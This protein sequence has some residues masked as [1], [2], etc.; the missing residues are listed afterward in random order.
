MEQQKSIE[1][2]NRRWRNRPKAFVTK[3]VIKPFND[4]D[5]IKLFKR[6]RNIFVQQ[7]TFLPKKR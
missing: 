3:D 2:N 1:I 5:V 7:K 6:K 4:K